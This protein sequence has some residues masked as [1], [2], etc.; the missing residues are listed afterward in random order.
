MVMYVVVPGCDEIT[1]WVGLE[2]V[3]LD[4]LMM[5]AAGAIDDN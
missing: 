1:T 4:T 2:R 5:G 3:P